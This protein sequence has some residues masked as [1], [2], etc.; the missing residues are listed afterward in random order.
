MQQWRTLADVDRLLTVPDDRL[1]ALGLRLRAIGIGPAFLARLARVGDRL[2]DALRAPMRVWNARRI[3]EPAAVAARLFILH[4][5]VSPDEVENALGQLAPL[6]DCG[7]IEET[8]DG[9][10]SRCHLALA[11][12]VYCFGDRPG[13]GD[14]AVIPVCGATLDLVRAAMPRRPVHS[15]LDV[16][17]GAGAVGLLLA[18]VAH[19]VVATDLSPRALAFAR[20]NASVNGVTNIEL[21]QGDLFESV[22]G[23]RFDLIA[24]QP[25]FV[26]RRDNAPFSTFVH[27]GIRGDELALR[28]LAEATS[29]LA[30]AGRLLVLADWPLAA[31][32]PLDSRLRSALGSAHV[33][34]LVMQSPPKNLDDYCALHAAVEH[35]QLG[36][37]FTRAAIAQ[38]DHLER[39]G[40]RGIALAF[41]VV[42]P[43]VHG[44]GW[45]SFL[46]V[47]HVSDAPIS[48]DTIDRLVAARRLA[49]GESEAM[50]AARL[51]LPQGA[52]LVPQP[53]PDG[54]PP[55]VIV[56]I[57]AGRPEWPVVLDAP[58]ARIVSRIADAPTVLDATR[59]A[60]IEEVRSIDGLQEHVE[61]VARDALLSGALDIASDRD[62]APSSLRRVPEER[63]R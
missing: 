34:L 20:I 7:L 6:H 52:V 56:Q 39:L 60:A 18:R 24:S 49:N 26:A 19:R 63:S 21:R 42:E 58:S 14:H 55:A 23:N 44:E 54:L 41:V 15:A 12:D 16:G 37:A 27:G 29:L 11:A 51:R 40:V 59:A 2:D 33:N 48:A 28:L 36:E 57:P 43:T 30:P 3:R 13:S 53:M 32:D 62:E 50:A 22:R 25:P 38:R 10:A 35:Q 1:R 46:A 17:C 9:I 5:A 61:R 47:R 31:G 45:T 8:G 4:D